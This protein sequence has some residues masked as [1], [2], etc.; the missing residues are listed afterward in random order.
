MK[1]V[2]CTCILFQF[3]LKGFFKRS[4]KSLLNRHPTERQVTE[5]CNINWPAAR[6]RSN[7]QP[8][9]MFLRAKIQTYSLTVTPSGTAKTVTVSGS[10]HSNRIIFSIRRL[11]LGQVVI[12]TW[13]HCI[14]PV[15]RRGYP[16]G[17]R[18]CTTTSTREEEEE[19]GRR[20]R[21]AHGPKDNSDF[22]ESVNLLCIFQ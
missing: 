22:T 6:A 14:I 2:V 5:R 18:S 15:W 17:R 21:S 3:E 8:S 13:K 19:R 20:T 16:S 12:I 4:F 10:S 7:L 9:Y 1:L 11:F